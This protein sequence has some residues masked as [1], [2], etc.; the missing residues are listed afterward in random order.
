VS[1]QPPTI[2]AREQ[3]FS[4]VCRG[5]LAQLTLAEFLLDGHFADPAKIKANRRPPRR[6]AGRAKSAAMVAIA[7]RGVVAARAGSAWPAPRLANPDD[8]SSYAPP[9]RRR[10]MSLAIIM[11]LVGIVLP[12]G[13][14]I[15]SVQGELARDLGI[16]AVVLAAL[17]STAVVWRVRQAQRDRAGPRAPSRAALRTLKWPRNLSP[18]QFEAHCAAYLRLHG[19]EVEPAR[20]A[21]ADDVYLEA[22]GAAGRVVM[23]CRP[24]SEALTPMAIRSVSVVADAFGHAG[25]VVVTQGRASVLGEQMAGQLGVALLKVADLPRLAGFARPVAADQAPEPGPEAT[26]QTPAPQPPP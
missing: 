8:A 16:A 7:E 26:M 24:R 3:P 18:E 25:A 21:L 10:L 12:L 5:C 4:G 22:T 20:S 9:R 13:L 14:I 1:P 6:T 11:F 23:L 2:D 15:S 17:V 19:W